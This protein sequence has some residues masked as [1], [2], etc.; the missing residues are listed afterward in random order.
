MLIETNTTEL[1]SSMT[2]NLDEIISYV[3]PIVSIIVTGIIGYAIPIVSIIITGIISYAIPIVS[4]VVTGII[5]SKNIS[6]TSRNLFIQMNQPEIVENMKELV[7]KIQTGNKKD[8]SVFLDSINRVYIPKQIRKKIKEKL[9]TE[10]DDDDVSEKGIDDMI[11]LINEHI[12]S[13]YG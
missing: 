9:E 7:Q 1:L 4:I 10:S 11:D 13:G 5:A 12:F 8:I 2:S 3:I 6:A